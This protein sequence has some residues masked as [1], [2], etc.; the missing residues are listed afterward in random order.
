MAGVAKQQ[1]TRHAI[2][3][4]HAAD[5]L[6]RGAAACC[7]QLLGLLGM[8]AGDNDAGRTQHGGT[9]PPNRRTHQAGVSWKVKLGIRSMFRFT[10]RDVLWLTVVVA[11]SIAWLLTSR[12]AALLDA[13]LQA[14]ERIAELRAKELRGEV[15][16]GRSPQ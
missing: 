3:P 12:R 1:V 5:R 4:P 15:I 7:W 14:F 2:P 11:V 16:I 8:S 13:R 6:G 9:Q 10:I